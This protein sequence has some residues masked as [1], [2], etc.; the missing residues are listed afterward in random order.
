MERTCVNVCLS[1]SFFQPPRVFV[2]RPPLPRARPPPPPPPSP[3]LPPPPS[4]AAAAAPAPRATP[5]RHE[6]RSLPRPAEC[7]RVLTCVQ[8]ATDAP[9]NTNPRDLGGAVHVCTVT[10]QSRSY[11]KKE[12]KKKK[13]RG[14]KRERER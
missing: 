4:A 5:A 2:A 10:E 6:T 11:E 9:D 14:R 3:S 12:K 1:L 13:R 8:D 7:A